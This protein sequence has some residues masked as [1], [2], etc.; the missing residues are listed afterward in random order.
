MI[1]GGFGAGFAGKGGFITTVLDANSVRT[2]TYTPGADGRIRV[3][4][5]TPIF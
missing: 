1:A 2:D 5:S 4:T 3:N